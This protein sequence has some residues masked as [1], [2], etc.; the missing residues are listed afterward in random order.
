MNKKP[1]DQRP[2]FGWC[3][4]LDN[5]PQHIYEKGYQDF[6]TPVVVIPLPYMSAKMRKKIREFTN[7]TIWPKE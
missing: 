1:T 4:N 2:R 6:R 7:G 5:E 3:T